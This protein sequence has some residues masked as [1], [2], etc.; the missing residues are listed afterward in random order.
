MANNSK[1]NN[2]KIKLSPK[3]AELLQW[4]KID[5]VYKLLDSGETPNAVCKW[6]NKNGFK[7]STPLIYDFVKIREQA[8]LNG[9]SMEKILGVKKGMN[10]ATIKQGEKFNSKKQ[11]LKNEIDALD[12]IISMGYDSL[13]KWEGKPMPISILMQ[14]IKLKNDLTDGYFNGLTSYGLEQLQLLEKQKYDL[15]LDILMNFIPEEQREAATTA[16][17][18]AEEDF[19]KHSEYYADYLRASGLT[20]AEV[21]RKLDEWEKEQEEAEEDDGSSVLEV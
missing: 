10:T 21:Q 2:G 15:I 3:L 13:D 5:Y 11:K 16:I 8:V 9:I 14:A 19:Y 17:E 4:E 6:I 18:E 7:L 20:E 1:T 12:R